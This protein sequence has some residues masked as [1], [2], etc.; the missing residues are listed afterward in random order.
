MLHY[1]ENDTPLP[2]VP[3]DLSVAQFMLDYQHE[4]RPERHSVACLVNSSTSE[5]ISFDQVRQRTD[6]LAAILQHK[7]RI[8]TWPPI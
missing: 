5:A 1:F 6:A 7:Y 3:E 8:G 4:I 2:Y